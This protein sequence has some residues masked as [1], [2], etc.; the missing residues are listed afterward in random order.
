MEISIAI[1]YLYLLHLKHLY[2]DFFNQ[3][4]N[5]VLE[6]GNYGSWLG[7]WHSLNHGIF[8]FAIFI[9]PLGFINSL[10]LGLLDFIIHYHVDWLKMQGT[11]DTK[12]PKFWQYLGLDQFA[13][14]VTYLLIIGLANT[15]WI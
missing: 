6:K 14:V 8:T 9:I 11:R 15:I 4:P 13:H 2:I 3:T 7:I 1:F 10:F 12:D 5:E